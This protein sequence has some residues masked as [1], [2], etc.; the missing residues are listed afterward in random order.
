[1][2]SLEAGSEAV[3]AG[4]LRNNL[5][6]SFSP[7]IAASVQVRAKDIKSKKNLPQRSALRKG[8]L[9]NMDLRESVGGE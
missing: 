7:R 6:G 4:K 8:G 9:R 1:M 5:W 3:V 2:S